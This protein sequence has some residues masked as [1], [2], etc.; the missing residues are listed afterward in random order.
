MRGRDYDETL[1]KLFAG[2][3]ATQAVVGKK[4]LRGRVRRDGSDAAERCGT[5]IEEAM[6]RA[7][8]ARER[9]E[10]VE[11]GFRNWAARES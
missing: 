8:R 10:I 7:R 1:A 11:S 6:E 3:N 5:P 4:V 9:F 2:L